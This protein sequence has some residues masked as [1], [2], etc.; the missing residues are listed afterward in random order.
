MQPREAAAAGNRD[1]QGRDRLG[2]PMQRFYRVVLFIAV[3]A[4]TFTLLVVMQR[5]IGYA[6]VTYHPPQ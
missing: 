5:L 3:T 4:V 1:R 2:T 6:W